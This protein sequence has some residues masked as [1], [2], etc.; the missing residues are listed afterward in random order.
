MI[1][2][3]VWAEILGETEGCGRVV[4]GLWHSILLVFINVTSFLVYEKYQLICNTYYK[5]LAQ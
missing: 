1:F 3:R 2:A 5:T 4:A